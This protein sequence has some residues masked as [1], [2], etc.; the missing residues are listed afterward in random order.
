[1]ACKNVCRLCN[2]LIISTAVAF[3][4]GS[5]VITIPQA[6]YENGEKY[7][8]VVA[9]SIPQTTTI[10]APVAIQIG[11]GTQL[12]SLVTRDCEA[13]SACG[14]RTRTKYSTVVQTSA[15]GGVFRMLGNP[16]CMP[17]YNRLSIDGNA[18][19]DNRKKGA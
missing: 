15:T 19:T 6:N 8:I 5:L 14:I 4:D 10:N 17:N 18:P 3:T 16:S 9:Q 2:R 1:M 7:C 12:Y 13:V 11:T